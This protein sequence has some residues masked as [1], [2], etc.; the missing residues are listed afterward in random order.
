[1]GDDSA[2]A[3]ESESDD[4]DGV[5]VDKE[6]SSSKRDLPTLFD[7]IDNE[8]RVFL[9]VVRLSVSCFV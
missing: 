8:V 9:F 2:S 7:A 1:M 5:K 6:R 4:D 3:A